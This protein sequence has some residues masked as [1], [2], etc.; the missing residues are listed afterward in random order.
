MSSRLMF[1]LG[2]FLG[3]SL[4]ISISAASAVTLPLMREP[5]QDPA[6]CLKKENL[7][8]AKSMAG[9]R[10]RAR[11]GEA[12]LI[13]GSDSTIL[14]SGFDSFSLISGVV[15]I[16][17]EAELTVDTIYGK[18]KLTAGEYILRKHDKRFVV[19]VIS[20][21]AKIQPLGYQEQLEVPQGYS[22]WISQVGDNRKSS[23]GFPSAVDFRWLI[24]QWARLQDGTAKEF[25]KKVEAFQPHW[26]LAVESV[27]YGHRKI[28]ES[29][30]A[31]AEEDRKRRWQVRKK[32]EKENRA[33]R[34]MFYQ[35]V[36]TE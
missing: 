34:E 22:N 20:G 7:C 19:D 2:F 35:K 25:Y 5:I 1:L 32:R 15:L 6:S 33:L 8:A 18:A 13:L 36:F 4:D 12:Q 11:V 3:F 14:R 30:I 24:N 26:Q 23:V 28:C 17:V 21:L 9:Y 29:E 10:A 27:S 31:K 16:R